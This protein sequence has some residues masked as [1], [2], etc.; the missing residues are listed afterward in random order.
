MTGPGY[1]KPTTQWHADPE[2][3]AVGREVIVTDAVI[4]PRRPQRHTTRTG[5]HDVALDLGAQVVGAGDR[6]GEGVGEV[7]RVVEVPEPRDRGVRLDNGAAGRLVPVA[8]LRAEAEATE[9]NRP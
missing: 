6:T 1:R 3:A 7:P 5:E 4:G 2:L 9:R 8:E